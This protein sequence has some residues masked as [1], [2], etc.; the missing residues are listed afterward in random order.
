MQQP[1]VDLYFTPPQAHFNSVGELLVDIHKN[2]PIFSSIF[3]ELDHQTQVGD[4][5]LA[6]LQ[7]QTIIVDGTITIKMHTLSRFLP[8]VVTLMRLSKIAEA[9]DT[10]AFIFEAK[11]RFIRSPIEGKFKKF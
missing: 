11:L 1:K 6:L 7:P 9:D 5:I 3:T 10:D 4:E 2:V 8:V